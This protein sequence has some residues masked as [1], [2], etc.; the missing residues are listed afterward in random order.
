MTNSKTF[1]LGEVLMRLECPDRSRFV[2]TENFRVRYTGAELNSA[3]TMRSLGAENLHLIT[4]VPDNPLGESALNT[5]NRWGIATSACIR[6]KGRLGCFY[7][8]QGFGVRPSSVIYDRKYSAFS[9][10]Q[11][12]D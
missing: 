2:Q 6:K 10:S 4:A 5:A 1:F 12:E 8:E 7:L 11:Y 9:L 3:V